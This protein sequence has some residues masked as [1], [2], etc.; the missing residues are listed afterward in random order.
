MKKRKLKRLILPLRQKDNSEGKHSNGKEINHREKDWTNK[1]L[2]R[3][4]H[5]RN[6]F[7]C[8]SE[9]YLVAKSPQNP[10]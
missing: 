7:V 6:V 3:E 1:T 2:V 5:V 10:N 4:K 9:N 8:D